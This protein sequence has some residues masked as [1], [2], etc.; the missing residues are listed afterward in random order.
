M[1]QDEASIPKTKDVVKGASMDRES[2]SGT[3]P[4]VI[5]KPYWALVS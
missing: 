3:C 4:R 5:A 2:Q 1:R